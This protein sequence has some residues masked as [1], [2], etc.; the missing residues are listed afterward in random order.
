MRWKEEWYNEIQPS[1]LPPPIFNIFPIAILL[2]FPYISP[3]SPLLLNIIPISAPY[4]LTPTF[5]PTVYISLPHITMQPLYFPYLTYINPLYYRKLPHHSPYFSHT[6]LV[7]SS[8][9]V[10][11]TKKTYFTSSN[12]RAHPLHTPTIPPTPPTTPIQSGCLIHLQAP[13]KTRVFRWYSQWFQIN[14]IMWWRYAGI[15]T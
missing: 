2:H 1:T 11:T 15:I 7:L 10:G 4:T 8:L 12:Y 9:Y 6:E 13:Q 14:C 3:N 5:P